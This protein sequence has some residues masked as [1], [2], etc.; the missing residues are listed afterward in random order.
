MNTTKPNTKATMQ[1]NVPIE[2]TRNIG[3]AAHIDAGKTTLTERILFYA[4]A[5]HHAGDVHDG[6]TTM[7]FDP[8]EQRKGI[9]IAAAAISCA[10]TPKPEDGLRKPFEGVGHRI[11]IIDTPG[12]VDF[13]AEVERSMR[14]LDGTIAVFSGVEGVQPQSERVWRQATR[15]AVPRLAFINKMDR[16]GADFERVA[17]ELRTRLNANAWPVLLPFGDEDTLRGQID[18]IDGRAIVYDLTQRYGLAYSVTELPAAERERAAT[19]R[20]ALI[21]ALAEIDDPIADAFLAE[22]E[23]GALELKAAIRRQTIANRFVPVIGG[24]A[25]KYIG[26]QALLD[27]VVDYLPSPIDLPP[28]V[29]VDPDTGEAIAVP[30]GDDEPFRA[31]VF[32]LSTDASSRRHVFVRIYSG[33]LRP[34]DLVLNTVTGRRERISR[35]SEIRADDEITIEAAFA[36]DIVVVA[37]LKEVATGHTLS[38]ESAPVL[39]APATFPAPVVS[40]AIEPETHADQE[41][42]GFALQRLAEDDPTFKVHTD[43]E[44]GQTL[45]AGM[46]ELHLEVILERMLTNFKVATRAGAPEIAYKETIT[47]SATGEGRHIKQSGGSGQYGH[48]YVE[49]AP[50]E[51]GGG[52]VVNDRIVGGSIPRQFI[53][54]VRKGILE[55]AQTGALGGH[56][57]VDLSVDIVDGSSHS[58]D[59]NDLAFQIAGS[60]AFKD[61]VTRARPVLLEPIM[62]VECTTPSAYQDDIVGDLLRR[63]GLVREIESKANL[64]VITAEVPLAEMFGYASAIRS[65]SKGRTDYSMQPARFEI[66]PAELAARAL[67][68]R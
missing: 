51:R 58:K 44:T 12:H 11:N 49:V 33:V 59:S 67:A 38:A 2:Q 10:W 26:V 39:L 64:A 24:S 61:A 20:H 34:G 5:I 16:V 21:A 40:M 56:P 14:V 63:R 41:R 53:A 65:L 28:A 25:F 48:V 19:A 55:A 68:R 46:G 27:A 60:L 36:G 7:D 66:V 57:V 1:R 3:I 31:L 45:I 18:V 9:T 17:A 50:L 43:P 52:L 15:Y 32:K 35:V 54:S 4:G 29:G 30:A 13:T 23:I 47:A 8:I 6:N 42:L 62:S 37:G 22:R